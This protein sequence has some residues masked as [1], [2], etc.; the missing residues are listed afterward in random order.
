[1]HFSIIVPVLNEE[2]VLEEPAGRPQGSPLLCYEASSIGHCKR[3]QCFFRLL[4]RC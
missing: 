2:V 4:C 1:M 3:I